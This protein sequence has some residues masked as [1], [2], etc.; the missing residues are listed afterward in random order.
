MKALP[1][2]VSLILVFEL[3]LTP[4]CPDGFFVMTAAL[5]FC[6][7]FYSS[8]FVC[9]TMLQAIPFYSFLYSI[10]FFQIDR[11]FKIK[12]HNH[13]HFFAFYLVG[14]LNFSLLM[15]EVAYSVK[16]MFVN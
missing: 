12:S 13:A 16:V 2:A 8:L 9:T 3:P 6:A 1:F 15:S 7:I 14:L 10:F 11:H 4:V 5:Y